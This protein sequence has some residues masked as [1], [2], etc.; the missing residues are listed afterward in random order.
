MATFMK[1]RTVDGY[2]SGGYV[3]DAAVPDT[4]DEESVDVATVTVDP[5]AGDGSDTTRAGWLTDPQNT[6]YDKAA[7]TVRL[8]SAG[9]A[10]AKA[11]VTRAATKTRLTSDLRATFESSGDIFRI[12]GRALIGLGVGDAAAVR[13]A[14]R[15]AITAHLDSLTDDDLDARE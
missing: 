15:N 2:L 4:A 13:T 6:V 9:E 8:A 3:A 11:G 14:F 12:I 5:A 10:A 7:A 1:Y